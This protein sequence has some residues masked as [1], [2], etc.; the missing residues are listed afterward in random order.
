MSGKQQGFV[1]RG[2]GTL[3]GGIEFANGIGFV[4]EELDAQGAVGFG[5]VDVEDAAADGVLAGHLDYVGGGVADG[6]EVREQG[7]EVEGFAAADGAGEIGVV[8]AG[9]QADGGGRDRGDHDG[10]GAGGDLP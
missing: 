3:R 6:V 10:C 8:I 9:A 1:D 4:A 5:R 2:G 7:F